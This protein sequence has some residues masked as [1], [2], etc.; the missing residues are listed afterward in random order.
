MY[1][2]I[3]LKIINFLRFLLI[4]KIKIER[5]KQVESK[6]KVRKKKKDKRIINVKPLPNCNNKR[7][8]SQYKS[9]N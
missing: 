5:K 1:I 4:I 7:S 8:T 2:F 6:I 3:C 9:C